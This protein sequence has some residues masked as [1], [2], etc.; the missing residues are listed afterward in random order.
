MSNDHDPLNTS[1]RALLAGAG[2]AGMAGVLGATA[3][4]GQAR[5][6]EAHERI[7]VARNGRYDTVELRQ[8]A[9]NVT[10]IQSR[11][12]SVDL[13]NLRRTNRE[14]LEHVLKLIDQAQGTPEEWGG[15]RLWGAKQDLLCLHEFP[16]QGWQPWGRTELQ[17]VAYELPGPESEAIGERAR[18]YDCYISWG[19]YVRDPDWP[20]HILNL[21]ILTGPDGSIVARQWKGRNALGLFGN[22][23][24][25]GTTVYD[26]L[27]RFVEMYGWDEVLPVA[28]TDIG[29][30][31]LTAVGLEPLLYQ[32][33]ALKGTELLVMTVTG[34]S[35]AQSAID[36][37]RANRI[38]TVGVGNSVTQGNI[39]FPEATG[40]RGDGSVIV[41]PTGRTL[42]QTANHHEDFASTRIPIADFR[43]TRR[44][45]EI[46]AAIL[47]PVLQ[48]YEPTFKPNGFMDRLPET[49]RDAADLVRERM[50]EG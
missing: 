1:R 6:D 10:A 24:L 5:A 31:A 39:G 20:G 40:V 50:S 4:T 14:N 48:Q 21:S 16:I 17:R 32:C 23:A 19:A 2:A 46:P 47:L 27:D 8:Q 25:I 30:I 29:N 34:G 7:S 44:F 18:R 45:P 37:A 22:F 9:I 11:V 12:R 38:Y 28:R 3:A 33:L 49:Y 13:N 42:A 15:E 26:V 43:A 41:D 36:T 35:N